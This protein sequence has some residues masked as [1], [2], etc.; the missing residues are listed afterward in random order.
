M[1]ATLKMPV[2]DAQNLML[3]TWSTDV[4]Y[5]PSTEM[6]NGGTAA[7]T[8][9]WRPG[10]GGLSVIEEYREKNEKGEVD[11]LGV[12]WWDASAHGQR[13]VWCDNTIP[14]GCYVSKNVAQWKDGKLIWSEEQEKA[15]QKVTSSE[16]FRDITPTSF[17]QILQEGESGGELRPLV[18]IRAT[19]TGTSVAQE[20]GE[21]ADRAAIKA[22]LDSHGA[23]WTRGDVTAATATLTEDADWVSGSGRVFVGR[24]AITKMHRDVLEG[25]AKGT[26]HS[27][28]GTPNIRFV[29][30]DVA[31]VD[32]DSYMAGF[33]DEHG[34]ELPG[35]YSRYTAVFVKKDGMWYVTAFRSLPQ[36][37]VTSP[38]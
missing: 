7:G 12:A 23:A 21:A 26:R 24:S 29:A 31:I 22:V 19:K 1:P 16:V 32:G 27:H 13:F 14:A 37:K 17:T 15:G 30:R 3:G 9:I 4:K 34:G 11:G 18:T 33:R 38:Q 5:E 10:P 8:E 2:P 35:E 28:P 20:S 25:P 36:V 6:P